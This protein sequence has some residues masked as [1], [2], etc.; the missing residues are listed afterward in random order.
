MASFRKGQSGNPAGRPRGIADKRVELRKLLEPHAEKL[1]SKVVALGLQGNV[2][3]LRLCLERL[4]PPIK[5]RDAPVD[6][7]PPSGSLVNQG[8]TAFE[9]LSA[10]KL[11]PDEAATLMQVISAQARIVEVDELEKRITVLEQA[12]DSHRRSPS[13]A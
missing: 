13:L 7:G 2:G 12:I 8:R 11:S 9:A 3:A 10:K 6:I 5:P 4:I 1:V